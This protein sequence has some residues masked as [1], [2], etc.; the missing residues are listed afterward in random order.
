M[1]SKLDETTLVT[2]SLLEER[3]LRL[4]HILYGLSTPT[5][6]PAETVA[7][8]LAE[9]ERRFAQL[10]RHYRVYSELLKI[11]MPSISTPPTTL[12]ES[13]LILTAS[14]PT[15]KSHPTLFQSPST[16]SGLPPTQLSPEAV[17]L[18]VL[19]YASDFPATA[20]A[21]TAATSDAPIPDAA[22]SAKLAALAPRMRTVE[23]LQR[24]QEV[25]MAE[26]R[27]RSER[28]LRIWYETGILRTGQALADA[29]SRLERVER[30]VRREERRRKDDVEAV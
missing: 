10:V 13:L 29:N 5:D 20:S 26:L 30:G 19:A 8:S 28:I 25:E 14:I 3:L 6:Q 11:C 2:L 12:R 18:T 22:Q 1:E 23:A 27:R 17:R 9:L 4:E 7:T 24:A 16:S 21:L 15:D